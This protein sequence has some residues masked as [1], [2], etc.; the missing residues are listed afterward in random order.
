[1]KYNNANTPA[2]LKY[3]YDNVHVYL[4]EYCIIDMRRFQ[5]TATTLYLNVEFVLQIA[6]SMDR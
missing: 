2:Q 3:R 5:A 4:L 6:M 1:V